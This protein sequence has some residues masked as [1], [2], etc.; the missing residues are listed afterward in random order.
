MYCEKMGGKLFDLVLPV[1]SEWGVR[2][3]A[4]GRGDSRGIVPLVVGDPITAKLYKPLIGDSHLGRWG[5][6]PVPGEIDGLKHVCGVRAKFLRS[7][8]LR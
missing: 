4:S 6:N 3:Y 8:K 5:T 7:K 1:G 2:R